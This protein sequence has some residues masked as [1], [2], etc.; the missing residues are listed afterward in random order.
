[1]N[2]QADNSVSPLCQHSDRTSEGSSDGLDLAMRNLSETKTDTEDPD[3]LHRRF[4]S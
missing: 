4:L 1:M 2:N 3:R